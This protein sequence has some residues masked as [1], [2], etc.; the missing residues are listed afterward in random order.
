MNQKFNLFAI[1]MMCFMSNW[2]SAQAPIF[3]DAYATGVT[4]SGF[5]G[6]TNDVTVDNTTFQSG[7]SSLKV[8]VPAAG[9]TGGALVAATAQNL[10]TYN[11][12]SFW[13]KGS[14]AKT[15][16]VAG[17]GN[18]SNTTVYQTEMANVA[19]TTTWTKV[20]I[21]IPVP[22][23]LT[24]ETGLFHFAEGADEGAYT[25]WLDNIQY[26]NLG[27]GVIGTATAAMATETINKAI[28]DTFSPNGLTCTF[29]VNGVS[30]TLTP[31]KAYFTYTSSTPAVATV[32][33]LGVGN[34]L[35]AGTTNITAALGA[36]AATGT[37]TVNVAAVAGPVT[38]ATTPTRPAANVMSLFSGAYTD[39]AG[40]DWA[41]IWGQST[42]VTEV[43]IAGNATKKY[44]NFNYQ[45][46]AL[47]SAINV[48]TMTHLHL[49]LWTPNC[50]SFQVFLISAGPIEQAV[51]LTPTLSGWNSW[52]I[53]LS[54]YTTPNK[55]AIFQLKFV[56]TPAGS[57]V[58]LD[59]IYFFKSTE[60][61]IAAPTPTRLAANVM[62]LFSGAYTD[63]AGTDWAPI[64]GQSTV[65]TEVP[66]AGNA[67][68]KYANFNYQGVALASAINV[69]TMTHLHLDLWTPDC[70]SFNVFLISPGP[71]EQAVP[72]T[73]TLEGWYSIDI[74]LSSYTTPNKAAIF[75]LKF[76]GTPAGS[77]VYLDNIYFY[78]TPAADPSQAVFTDD[79]AAGVTFVPFGGST[80]AVTVDNTTAQ[81]GTSSLKVVVPATGWTGGALAAATAQNLSTYNAVSFWVKGSAAKTLNVTGLGNNATPTGAVYQAEMLTVPVT[82]TW[83]KHIIPVPVPAKLNAETGLFHFAE[84]SD[85]GAYTI[86]FDNI[87]YE[88]ISGGVIGTPTA[89]MATETINKTIGDAFAPTGLTS[90]FPVNGV[91]K[92][93]I[94]K[95][96][97]FT[98]TS[99]TPAVATMSAS[100]VG[101]ALSAGTTNITAMLGAVAVT[102]T[103]TVNV[104][105]VAGPLTA[106]PT[107][108]RPVAS[109]ISLFSNAYTDVTGT[110][111]NPA[112]QQSTIVTDILIAGNTTKKY[113]NF[114]YQGVILEPAINATTMNYFHLD[115]WTPNC[116]SFKVFL[117]NTPPLVEQD[118]TFTPTLSGWN[119]WDIALSSYNTINKA[120]IKELKFVGTPTGS[121]VYLDNLFFFKT[122]V[123]TNDLKHSTDLFTVNP[124][125]ANDFVNINLNDNVKGSTQ[126]T[127]TTLTGQKVYEASLNAD[128]L[129]KVKEIS[130][131]NFAAGMYIIG[132]RVG[133]SFQT[134]KIV[135]SH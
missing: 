97:Y 99:S 29:P 27:G 13:I 83:T 100:G 121:V 41:P 45:G 127:F 114:N 112:W 76:V 133:D 33:A 122:G 82:T 17:L 116:T 5:G 50:T 43:P 101:S 105:A 53:S 67:T 11:A 74:A 62:S 8:V 111:W 128:N 80:N 47:A 115:V 71:L 9:Y 22:A 56:G 119:S 3:T 86:W 37:L 79:Y 6:S 93:V 118:V 36:V 25:I 16:N 68:K 130:T 70:T 88:A 44:A 60:P 87:Q 10:S 95:P 4:F 124:T 103:L 48:T 15:L 104:A 46:V 81:S 58:Y 24:A 73:P 59:N 26:E 78:K 120:S 131:Q 92:T 57:T 63:I 117:I 135:V 52:D 89:A 69:T 51:T 38:A 106:A 132:V 98:Y 49:D 75:Q 55:A 102:G 72:L 123:G 90:S 32:S 34:T 77:T 2:V 23:K 85:E 107:P 54:S 110:N 129:T 35:A 39:I 42:V 96:A 18:N 134:Q 125:L 31:S 113:A 109:V 65:V 12:V 30:K 14:A 1:G 84:G 91:A 94:P 28:G 126:I 64:W 19:V 40:T 108:T 20:I 21:P 7:T 61:L 66:I